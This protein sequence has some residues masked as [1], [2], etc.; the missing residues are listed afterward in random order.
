MCFPA[1][2]LWVYAT[3]DQSVNRMFLKKKWSI[4]SKTV[5][6]SIMTSI[7]GASWGPAKGWTNLIILHF[8]WMVMSGC[9]TAEETVGLFLIAEELWN[10]RNSVTAIRIQTW[11]VVQSQSPV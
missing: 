11:V 7:L 10:L 1:E 2:H 4:P 6:K 9:F 3:N 5:T 8:Y